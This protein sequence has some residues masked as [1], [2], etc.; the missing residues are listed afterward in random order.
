VRKPLPRG[1]TGRPQRG[2]AR[3]S[4]LSSRALRPRRRARPGHGAVSLRL[5]QPPAP[6]RQRVARPGAAGAASFPGLGQARAGPS[7]DSPVVGPTR[8]GH[9]LAPGGS[10]GAGSQAGAWHPASAPEATRPP[11]SAAGAVRQPRRRS[12]LGCTGHSPLAAQARGH[13]PRPRS[14]CTTASSARDDG[15]LVCCN[16]QVW[17]HGRAVPGAYGYS[18]RHAGAVPLRRY[19]H[20]AKPRSG[21]VTRVRR[22]FVARTVWIPT[23]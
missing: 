11:A 16:G 9:G 8:S 13:R 10:G 5:A 1:R 18:P 14:A 3:C 22:P 23:A 17:R 19:G 2:L 4:S 7:P 20:G 6:A 15:A 12:G 21:G